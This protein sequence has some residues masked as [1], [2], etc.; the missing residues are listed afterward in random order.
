MAYREQCAGWILDIASRQPICPSGA[1]LGVSN[2]LS[3]L[4]IKKKMMTRKKKKKKQKE[5]IGTNCCE[6]RTGE[7]AQ[8]G[9]DD[10]AGDEV[11]NEPEHELQSEADGDVQEDHPALA[12]TMGRLREQQAAQ[13]ST[14]TERGGDVPHRGH[15]AGSHLDQIFNHP[16]G[17]S[18]G[19]AQVEEVEHAQ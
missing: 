18:D 19:G 11:W 2:V 4:E 3:T 16:S 14:A 12:K 15:R 8:G 1:E 5:R 13:K 17:Y 10:D 9:V 7:E 6:E